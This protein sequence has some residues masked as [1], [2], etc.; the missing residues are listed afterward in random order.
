MAGLV[1]IGRIVKARDKAGS[2]IVEPFF[3]INPE[4]L[5]N[6]TVFVAPPQL[7]VNYVK[8]NEALEYNGRLLIFLKG[9]NT[10]EKANAL[11]QR[12]L[13]VP[14]S[15]LSEIK[16][17]KSNELED[18][19]DFEIYLNDGR[20]IGNVKEVIF[21]PANT[22]IRTDYNK[23]EILI[24]VVSEFIDEIDYAKRLIVL[25]SDNFTKNWEE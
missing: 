20:K 17:D 24:P 15:I 16:A 21:T 19:L 11:K 14:E 1:S 18:L 25:N 9:I 6:L 3:D 13:Q 8:I 5:K 4:K 22:V 12:L 10:L 23:K 2:L 7:D